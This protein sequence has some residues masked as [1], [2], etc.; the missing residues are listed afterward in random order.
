MQITPHV[1]QENT[2]RSSAIDRRI[3]PHQR[4]ATSQ[5]KRKRVE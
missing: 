5:Q 1:G 3:T 4:Y 2:H